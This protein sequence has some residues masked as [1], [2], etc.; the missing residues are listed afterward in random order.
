MLEDLMKLS[1]QVDSSKIIKQLDSRAVLGREPG[2]ELCF[3]DKAISRKHCVFEK[4]VGMWQLVDLKS[5]NNT[6]L[7]GEKCTS[8]ILAIGDHIQV[9][10][11]Q[12]Q[13]VAIGD[14]E[15]AS[16]STAPRKKAKTMM[17][18]PLVGKDVGGYIPKG[19]LGMGSF[20]VVYRAL[21]QSLEREVA[22]K[23]LSQNLSKDEAAVASFLQEARFAAALTH[24]NLVQVYDCGHDK[25]NV[26][27]SMEMIRGGSLEEHLQKNGPIP[28]RE[29]LSAIMDCLQ[30]LDYAEGKGLVHRDV[31]PANLMLDAR[32]EVKLADLGM[33]TTR[34]MAAEEHGGTPHFMAPECSMKEGITDNRSDLYALGCTFFRLISGRHVFDEKG[35]AAVLRAHRED[36][37]PTFSDVSISVPL[38]V[39][40]F[41]QK[42]LH[43]KPS[44]RY[45]SAQEMLQAALELEKETENAGVLSGGVAV[46]PVV[47]RPHSGSARQRRLRKKSSPIS[48]IIML[49]GA[50]AGLYWAFVHLGLG[51]QAHP[52]APAHL[53]QVGQ[54][55]P[56]GIPPDG[57][58][59][60]TVYVQP[61]Q[62]AL[63]QAFDEP[64]WQLDERWYLGMENC[65]LGFKLAKAAEDNKNSGKGG[66]YRAEQDAAREKLETGLRHFQSLAEDYQDNSRASREI[67]GLILKYQK[68]L[69]ITRK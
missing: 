56:V 55:S 12:I 17:A 22:L 26:F 48:M 30:A 52:E 14:D 9:G 43:K 1:I 33:A 34:E 66:S 38:A 37:P 35:V 3:S 11:V 54:E 28:W 20:G 5:A 32:G 4:N 16:D 2:C 69:T 50:A 45:S 23:V 6:W 25:N 49:L 44:W 58:L 19:I 7:N 8:A 29:A 60:T 21:Q 61:N 57:Q 65:Q 62:V 24:P 36:I 18:E 63:G 15:V 46:Q 67:E 47:P 31:K 64:T 42:T 41:L 59:T 40:S 68:A 13:V 39:E 53:F 51:A 27:Y 10:D